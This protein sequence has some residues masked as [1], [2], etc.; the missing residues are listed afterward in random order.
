MRSRT[1]VLAIALTA[2]ATA[3]QPSGDDDDAPAIDARPGP[4]APDQ[5]P[6]DAADPDAMPGGGE[7][8]AQEALCNDG[9]DND[10]DGQTDCVDTTCAWACTA[11]GGAC[12]SPSNLRAY[13]MAP[14]PQTI[15]SSTTLNAMVIVAQTGAITVAAIRFNA[16]HTFDGD[17]D[18]TVR[19]PANTAL[20]ITSDNGG[21]TENYTNTVFIDSAGTE[22]ISGSGPFTGSY[23]PEAALS[24][25]NNQSITGTW[26]ATL[27]DDAAGDTGT[28]QELSL[29]FCVTP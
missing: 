19:S 17:I 11:L 9:F 18:L 12:S 28:W 24:G 21:L 27:A 8:T 26:S 22:V 15:P 13:S 5:V 20:D 16:V 2:C 14:M 23:R 1:V 29:G 6:I 4:D 7:V 10:N 25:W 3:T